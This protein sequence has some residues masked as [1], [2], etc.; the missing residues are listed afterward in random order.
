[1]VSFDYDSYYKRLFSADFATYELNDRDNYTQ[2][3]AYNRFNTDGELAYSKA[4]STTYKL[5]MEAQ[6][7]YARSF[8]KH[9]VT[10][11]CFTTRTTT[12]I[13][14]NWPNATKDW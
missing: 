2:I 8:G 6:L 9:D 3:D 13:I 11:W 4:T 10:A 7:N 14:P 1:M 5:Y 12:A